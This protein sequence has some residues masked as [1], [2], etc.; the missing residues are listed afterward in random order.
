MPLK[1]LKGFERVELKA[2]ETKT[3]SFDLNISDVYFFDETTQSNYVVNGAYTIK[4]GSNANDAN[5]LSTTVNVSGSI[6]K[7]VKNVHAAPTGIKL[8][9]AVAKGETSVAPA[10]YI[11]SNASAALQDDTLITDLSTLS[12][13][14]VTYTSSNEDVAKVDSN[15]KVTASNIEGTALIT[16][17]I[18]PQSGTPVT[19]SFPVVTQL[20]EKVAPEVT[21]S[22]LEK[23]ENAF[24]ACPEIAYLPENWETILSVYNTAKTAIESELLEENLPG[25]LKQA[26]AD[27]KAVP[28]IE[29]AETY[30]IKS[31]NPSNIGTDNELITQRQESVNI[32][33]P[34][35]KYPEQSLLIHHAPG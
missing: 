25:I 3:V 29:L 30:N 33:L 10:N 9:G 5:A 18:T 28:T 6:S 19:D 2:G 27:L 23:L 1:Q 15:G 11:E 14:T 13:A 24:K 8:Y 7:N 17:T 26:A 20:K 22:Y 4:V 34:K 35:P 32:Q 21:A 31:T 12:N 16:V